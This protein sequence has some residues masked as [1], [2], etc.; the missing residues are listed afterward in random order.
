MYKSKIY[1]ELDEEEKKNYFYITRK[2]FN[3]L[4]TEIDFNEY[5]SSWL[6]RSSQIIFL[7][8]TCFNGLFRV[9][10]KG[11]FNVP[12]GRYKNPTICDEEN[13]RSVAKILQRTKILNDDFTNVNSFVNSETFVYFDPPYRPISKTASF[14]SYAKDSFNDSEQLRLAKFFSELNEK[15]AKLML[16]NSNPKNVKPNDNF[17]D[18]AYD[19]YRIERIEA[20]RNINSNSEK[21]GPIRELLIMNYEWNEL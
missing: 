16:S 17:F 2:E 21:R 1:F 18:D 19:G 8:R 6:K 13:L 12:F 10:G 4:L 14:N 11:H 3:D 5:Q 15:G 7:N 20:L 9:N